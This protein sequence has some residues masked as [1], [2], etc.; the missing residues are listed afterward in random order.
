MR[1]PLYFAYGSNMDASAMAARCPR[2]RLIGRG[3]LAGYRTILMASGF[4]SV[5]PDR[6]MSVHGV[7]WDVA[8]GDVAALDRYEDVAR[9]LYAKKN[10]AILREP[11]GSV[12]ALTYVGGRPDLGAAP[13]GY[14]DGVIAAARAQA[15][16]GDY[17]DYLS[18][19]PSI[20]QSGRRP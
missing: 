16:P 15:L 7:L 13:R 1:V 19:L 9:G 8:V 18:G 17:I 11:V 4:V 14:F 10:F 2:S 3:R 20:H 12:H 6:R 5:A